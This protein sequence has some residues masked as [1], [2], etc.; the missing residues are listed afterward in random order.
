MN[1]FADPFWNFEQLRAWAWWRDR[2]LV[3]FAGGGQIWRAIK[4]RAQ[5]RELRPK[6]R[7]LWA[8]SELDRKTY[9]VTTKQLPRS[10]VPEATPRSRAALAL[11]GKALTAHGT[12]DEHSTAATAREAVAVAQSELPEVHGPFH[13]IKY[14]RFPMDES[15]LH[16]FQSDELRATG[17][18]PNEPGAREISP[19]DWA[20][21][22]IAISDETRRLGVWRVGRKATKIDVTGPRPWI[23]G[24]N[25]GVGDFE[26][27]R[28]RRE[29]ILKA[30]PEIMPAE[31]SASKRLSDA[32]V[33]ALI[34]AEHE[35][36][37]RR[38]PIRF[39]DECAEMRDGGVTR[40]RFISVW[41][42][43]HPSPK[44]GRPEKA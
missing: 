38:T 18:L 12:V 39:W 44:R 23:K 33:R 25:P 40:D 2:D 4:G 42:K 3:N 9:C 24:P 28:I 27:V 16:L 43:L 11:L 41:R 13:L 19:A 17:S 30:F 10:P 36:L 22:E 32:D 34:R 21:L 29:G 15:L 26:N 31:V 7:E 37:G 1:G 14:Y 5:A 6:I 20:G 8:A 35:K